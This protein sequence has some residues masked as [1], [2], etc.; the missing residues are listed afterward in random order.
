MH[1]TEP[2]AV[3]TRMLSWLLAAFVRVLLTATTGLETE[4]VTTEAVIV[5]IR[6]GTGSG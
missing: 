4:Q 3:R 2:T 1:H 6:L 5:Q